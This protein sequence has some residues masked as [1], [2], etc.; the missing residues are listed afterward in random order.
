MPNYEFSAIAFCRFALKVALN[1]SAWVAKNGRGAMVRFWNGPAIFVRLLRLLIVAPS[2]KAAAYFLEVET[3]AFN[4][5]SF[6]ALIE[7]SKPPAS[8]AGACPG[9]EARWNE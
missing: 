6:R 4:I 5:A 3:R 1:F 7:L 8:T 2:S 9:A